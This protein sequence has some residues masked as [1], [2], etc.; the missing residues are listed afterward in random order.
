MSDANTNAVAQS[1]ESAE[2]PAWL[3]PGASVVCLSGRNGH[4]SPVLTVVRVMKRDVVLDNGDRWSRAHATA[5]SRSLYKRGG[6]A[7]Q[8]GSDLYPADAPEVTR[9]REAAAER[10]WVS[11]VRH[12][13][14][15]LNDAVRT[16]RWDDAA[17]AH[18]D[19]G[20]ALSGSTT[21]PPE[22]RE[23]SQGNPPA[24]GSST[25]EEAR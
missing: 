13:A 18:A 23:P 6:G 25:S 17:Q 11:R 4:P 10:A 12:L 7:W 2:C 22:W 3:R 15:L 21:I 20:A 9:A 5:N 19:L 1:G 16:G 14:S 8:P 24:I